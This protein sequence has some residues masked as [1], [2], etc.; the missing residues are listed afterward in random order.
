VTRL[1]YRVSLNCRDIRR[2]DWAAQPSQRSQRQKRT[3]DKLP[4]VDA[5]LLQQRDDGIT[6]FH[7]FDLTAAKNKVSGVWV[8]RIRLANG[9]DFEQ[10]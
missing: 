5:W 2:I 6:S 9:L 8:E 3:A 4:P 7:S 1:P 10:T